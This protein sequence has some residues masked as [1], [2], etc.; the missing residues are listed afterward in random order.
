[1]RALQ[2]MKNESGF[3][4]GMESHEAMRLLISGDASPIAKAL[5]I[6]ASTIARW[7]LPTEDYSQSGAYNPLDRLEVMMAEALR[8]GRSQADAFAPIHYLALAVGGVFLPPAPTV[9]KHHEFTKQMAVTMKEVGEFLAKGAEIIEDDK[10]TPAEKRE[11]MKEGHEALH[12]LTMMLS[13]G[14]AF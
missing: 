1:V 5:H 7:G 4:H 11:F 14:E 2:K 10:V 3:F 8:R 9:T 13:M 6:H 12:N